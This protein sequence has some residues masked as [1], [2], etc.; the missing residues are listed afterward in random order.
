MIAMSTPE[1]IK[2]RFGKYKLI[3]RLGMGGMAEVFKAEL[4]SNSSMV[5]AIKRILPQYSQDKKLVG[6]LV[7]EARLSLGLNH[8]HIVP[9]LDFGIVDGNYFMAMEYVRGKD[10]KSIMIRCKTRGTELPIQMAVYIMIK[11]LRGLD[12]AHTKRDHYDQP[13]HIVHRDISPQ[14]VIVSLWGEVKV[15]DFGIAK[16]ASRTIDTQ[17]GILKG[18]FSYMSPE[19]ARG[20]DIDHRTDI[21]S[22]GIVLWELLTLESCFQAETDVKLL[23]R[24][25]DG[26]VKSPSS[27]NSKVPKA[28]EL[29]LMKALEKKLKKR[30][31]TAEDFAHDL[32]VFQRDTIGNVTDADLAAFVRNLFGISSQ[33]LEPAPARGK[34]GENL[35]EAGIERAL[36]ETIAED[37]RVNRSPRRSRRVTTNTTVIFPPWLSSL[38]TRGGI[39]ILLLGALIAYPPKIIFQKFD[40]QVLRLADRIHSW[41]GF[42]VSAPKALP[43]LYLP[44]IPV[45]R[46][47]V[48]WLPE[49]WSDLQQLP[50]ETFE[51][52]RDRGIDL[53]N[54]PHPSASRVDP[55]QPSASFINQGGY[56]LHYQVDE[57]LHSVTID[58]LDKER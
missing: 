42:H 18:K 57:Q 52:V 53:G 32:E 26:K 2:N 24:V 23:A 39:F 44:P 22:A 11:V 45:S 6:M 19:Q 38:L 35:I 5:V 28:L 3:A 16:A 25:R 41:K 37:V 20:D 13:L 31:Q 56:R 51:Q 15:L 33:E 21:F 34:P 8:P 10:L 9:V 7:N 1:E 49:V 36:A 58:R 30:Y 12:H 4:L 50:F 29:I 40:R 46:F 48:Q 17:A 43:E 55:K 14:N 47:S 27:V 54:D